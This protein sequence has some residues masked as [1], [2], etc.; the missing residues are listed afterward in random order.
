M[1]WWPITGA[2]KIA[3]DHAR[4][5]IERVDNAQKA[6][7]LT[8]FQQGCAKAEFKASMYAGFAADPIGTT[9]EFVKMIRENKKS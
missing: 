4:K 9:L 3:A 2:G 5:V 1:G 6:G 8:P 7:T